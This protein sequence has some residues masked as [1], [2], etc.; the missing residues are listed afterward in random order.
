MTDETPK[1]TLE[2]S[3]GEWRAYLRR[4]QAIHKVDVE[5]LEDHLRSQ[6]HGLVDAGLSDD[7]AFLVAIKLPELFGFH[8]S[9]PIT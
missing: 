4:R 5:E 6:I 8:M 9:A 3:I 2:E 1:T 7:E